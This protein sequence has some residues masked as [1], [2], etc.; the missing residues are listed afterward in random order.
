MSVASGCRS[1][2]IADS[3]NVAYPYVMSMTALSF[4][5]T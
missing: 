2:V 3:S 4:P 5:R 1:G